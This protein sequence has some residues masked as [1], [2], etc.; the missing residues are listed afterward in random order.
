MNTTEKTLTKEQVLWKCVEM[1]T[2]RGYKVGGSYIHAD[3]DRVYVRSLKDGGP[4]TYGAAEC[5][6]EGVKR[7]GDW[8]FAVNNR[9]VEVV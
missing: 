9:I 7:D 5:F 4:G 1:M 6:I 8:H 2:D 3:Q